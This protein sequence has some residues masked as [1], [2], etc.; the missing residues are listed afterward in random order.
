MALLFLVF[1]TLLLYRRRRR[2]SPAPTFDLI[3]EDNLDATSRP[4]VVSQTGAFASDITPFQGGALPDMEQHVRT[5]GAPITSGQ[6]KSGT[7]SD[8]ISNPQSAAPPSIRQGEQ[9]VSS[10]VEPHVSPSPSSLSQARLP[11][12]VS[13][14]RGH[15]L[16]S[17]PTTPRDTP[18][19]GQYSQNQL[20]L[21]K[22]LSDSHTDGSVIAAVAKSMLSRGT[23]AAEAE[24]EASDLDLLQRLLDS[25]T[26]GS[27]IRGVAE[28]MFRRERGLP[29]AVGLEANGPGDLLLT[30]SEEDAPPRYDFIGV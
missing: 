19:D 12:H 6:T 7:P 17:P 2:P 30:R 18:T 5:E 14:A 15:P 29:G 3:D 8:V 4:G 16:A 10:K 23:A 20:K 11:P 13:D 25:D 21:L 22:K 27:V 26:D 1:A 9:A 28:S 24:L